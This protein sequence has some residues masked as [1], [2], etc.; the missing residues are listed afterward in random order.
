MNSEV[1]VNLVC[2][3]TYIR[4]TTLSR[5]VY[6]RRRKTRQKKA[7]ALYVKMIGEASEIGFKGSRKNKGNLIPV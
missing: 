4:A 1:D 6:R 2:C 7:E 3:I 5:L